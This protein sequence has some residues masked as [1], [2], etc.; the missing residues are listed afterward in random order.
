MLASLRSNRA[1]SLFEVLVTVAILSTAVIFLFRAFTT[2]LNAAKISQDI[3]VA[4][5]LAEE[6]LFDI[7]EGIRNN[8]PTLEEEGGIAIHN[9]EFNW[10][11]EV[12]SADTPF[13]KAIKL[14][15]YWSGKSAKE[16]SLE[17]INYLYYTAGK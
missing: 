7:E 9:K 15:L 12:N 17:F 2:S 11:Y 8:S 16:Y 1:F 13:L 14:I 3:F 4:C 6:R 5:L 10:H